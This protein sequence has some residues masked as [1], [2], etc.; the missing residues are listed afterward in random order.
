[1]LYRAAISSGTCSVLAQMGSLGAFGGRATVPSGS[2]PAQPFPDCLLRPALTRLLL[3]MAAMV[4]CRE[5]L[6]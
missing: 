4:N 3:C 6:A 2:S 5:G 1:M